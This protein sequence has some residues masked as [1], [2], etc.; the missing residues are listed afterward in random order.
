[1]CLLQYAF[2]DG[3]QT[4]KGRFNLLAKPP[5]PAVWEG[6]SRGRRRSGRGQGTKRQYLLKRVGPPLGVGGRL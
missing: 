4:A 3:A 6:P 5:E 1:M 2:L